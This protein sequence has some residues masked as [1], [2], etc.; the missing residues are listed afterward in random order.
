MC[1]SILLDP[2]EHPESGFV[3]GKICVILKTGHHSKTNKG[4]RMGFLKL[5]LKVPDP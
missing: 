1:F 5:L 3:R 4:V 2:A